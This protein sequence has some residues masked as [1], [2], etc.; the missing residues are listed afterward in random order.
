MYLIDSWQTFLMCFVEAK[1][2]LFDI[3]S[4]CPSEC[5]H[6]QNVY[7]MLLGQFSVNFILLV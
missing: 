1:E 6:Y 5:V 4:V 2:C 7:L 3:H